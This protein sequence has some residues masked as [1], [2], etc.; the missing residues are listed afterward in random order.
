MCLPFSIL[1]FP[2]LR[3]NFI[4]LFSSSF[5]SDS[6]AIGSQFLVDSPTLHFELVLSLCVVQ[7]SST[8]CTGRRS[9]EFF[10][11]LH[12]VINNHNLRMGCRQKPCM[13]LKILIL[14]FES[15]PESLMANDE[16]VSAKCENSIIFNCFY[17]DYLCIFHSLVVVLE[18]KIASLYLCRC[19]FS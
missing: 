18:Q 4:S 17:V 5:V 12:L 15:S 3:R 19:F 16:Y 8:S 11:Q 2:I 10:S 6:S 13:R 7:F 14:L 1:T 9:L